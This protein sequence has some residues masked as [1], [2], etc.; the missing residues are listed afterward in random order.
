MRTTLIF[1]LLGCV[2]GQ[3]REDCVRS[4]AN[5]NIYYRVENIEQGD[6]DQYPLYHG[7]ALVKHE[8]PGIPNWCIT[9]P[10]E[11]KPRPGEC[12]PVL[13]DGVIIVPF[14]ADEGDGWQSLANCYYVMREPQPIDVPAIR[15]LDTVTFKSSDA[16]DG[17]IEAS[18]A[19][20]KSFEDD[21]KRAHGEI[22]WSPTATCHVRN[23]ACADKSRILLTAEDGHKWCH[24][25]Q[26]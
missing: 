7:R 13:R 23:Y 3:T 14:E 26:P 4:K 2:W 22:Q 12:Y 20:F 24:K 10:Q 5:P 16:Y 9:K 8:V 15:S 17:S 1:M 21:C 25:V 6:S 18:A 19:G 11:W